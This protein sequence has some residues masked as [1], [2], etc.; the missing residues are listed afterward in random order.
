MQIQRLTFDDQ[1]NYFKDTK[2]SIRAKIGDVAANKLCNEAMFFV[3]IGTLTYHFLLNVENNCER[4][5]I[6]I[7]WCLQEVMTMSTISCSPSWQMANNTHTMT[8][9][10]S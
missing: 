2:E 7:W 1:I 6:I 4:I 8:L 10:S 3:G 5:N 9:S